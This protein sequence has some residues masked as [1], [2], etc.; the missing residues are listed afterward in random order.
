MCDCENIIPASKECFKQQITVDIPT[1]M[2]SYKQARLKNG[3][4]DQICI[5]PCVYNEIRELWD[6]GISTRGCCCGH[7]LYESFVNVV[8]SDI[9]KM[10][11]MH[12]V[13]NHSDKNRRDTFRMKSAG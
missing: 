1:H 10:I 4:S 7:N 13:M 3:L 5:D 2:E 11:G 8:E 12:Y 6:L 9:E